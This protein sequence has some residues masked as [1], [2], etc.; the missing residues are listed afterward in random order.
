MGVLIAEAKTP[1]I[2]RIAANSNRLFV[3]PETSVVQEKPM[4]ATASM[5]R[6]FHFVD[7]A[8]MKMLDEL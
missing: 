6:L 7:R 5:A 3:A 8:D 4:I 1:Y 2:N